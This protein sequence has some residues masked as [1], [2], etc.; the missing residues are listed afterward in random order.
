MRGI[1]VNLLLLGVW[2]VLSAGL[3]WGCHQLDLR[4]GLEP[5]A[6][7]LL[8]LGGELLILAPAIL[9]L[10]KERGQKTVPAE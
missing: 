8:W 1:I 9:F 2:A 5:R 4:I 6:A 10:W 7:V 3:V